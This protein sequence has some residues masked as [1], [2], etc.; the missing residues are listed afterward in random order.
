MVGDT[1]D[2]LTVI[3][4]MYTYNRH[5]KP[6]VQCYILLL[7]LYL[8]FEICNSSSDEDA[9]RIGMHT[10]LNGKEDCAKKGRAGSTEFVI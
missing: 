5:N 8:N 7:G 1:I 3:F 4:L 10:T 9:M 2:L 6:K